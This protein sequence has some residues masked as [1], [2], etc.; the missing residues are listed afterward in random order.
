VRTTAEPLPQGLPLKLWTRA[1]RDGGLLK[2][3]VLQ[4]L[5]W[6]AQRRLKAAGIG[7]NQRFAGVLFHP[8]A[9]V[10]PDQLEQHQFHRSAAFFSSPW[11]QQE[12]RALKARALRG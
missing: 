10:N 9:A 11:R 8:A 3:L 5:T 1:L 4:P 2:W 7:T 12:W 6:L